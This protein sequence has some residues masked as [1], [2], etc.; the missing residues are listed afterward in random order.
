M[1]TIALKPSHFLTPG[2][3]VYKIVTYKV[4]SMMKKFNHSPG[5]RAEVVS[6]E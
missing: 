3:K 4:T 2:N 1:W 5:A 6:V